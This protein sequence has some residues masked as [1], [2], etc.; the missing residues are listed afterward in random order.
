MKQNNQ[1]INKTSV[2]FSR[3]SRKNWAVFKSLGREVSIGHIDVPVAGQALRKTELKGSVL[4]AES[5][6]TNITETDSEEEST[7]IISSM[8]E[9]MLLMLSP[10]ITTE[11]PSLCGESSLYNLSENNRFSSDYYFIKVTS[12]LK[13][14]EFILAKIKQL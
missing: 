2:R 11:L 7:F 8:A 5:S 3:W 1:H 12:V 4:I 9:L 6:T 13:W 14:P 10:V